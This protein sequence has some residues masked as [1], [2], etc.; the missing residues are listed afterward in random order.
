MS[1]QSREDFADPWGLPA[2]QQDQEW[3]EESEPE[4][5]PPSEPTETADVQEEQPP[6]EAEEAPE[7]EPEPPEETPGPQEPPQEPEEETPQPSRAGAD[8]P[9]MDESRAEDDARE[10]EEQQPSIR[11]G[12]L[13]QALAAAQSVIGSLAHTEPAPPTEAEPE[14]D[15]GTMAQ[16]EAGPGP[17]PIAEEPIVEA[18]PEP[19]QVPSTELP[20]APPPWVLEEAVE[21]E[22]TVDEEIVAEVPEGAD[23]AEVVEEVV[24]EEF[25]E[26]TASSWLTD[27]IEETVSEEL[28][29]ELAEGEEPEPD[30]LARLVS[31]LAEEEVDPDQIEEVVDEL[32]VETVTIER[33]DD[34]PPTVSVQGA[35]QSWWSGE[36]A[37]TAEDRRDVDWSDED[38][39]ATEPFEEPGEAAPSGDWWGGERPT[40]TAKEV[41]PVQEVEADE[42]VADAAPEEPVDE[43]EPAAAE[44]STEEPV[45]PVG[46]HAPEENIPIRLTGEVGKEEEEGDTTP[47]AYSQLAAAAGTDERESPIEP[48]VAP[49]VEW[50]AL[51][52]E[53]AQ[54]WVED[55][56]GQATWRPIVTTTPVLS[57]WEVDTYLGVVAGE[58]MV[59]VNV[60]ELAGGLR[61]VAGGRGGGY[62][63]ELG[64]SRAAAVRSMVEEA[65]ARGSHAV[66]G[67]K[68]DYEAVGNALLVTASGTAV[69]LKSR[70]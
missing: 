29:I 51:W 36:E 59:P 42:P 43:Q 21:V 5:P 57:D 19:V 12:P 62:E 63:K 44:W 9:H 34:E 61:T 66:I 2:Q 13:S 22:V 14:P 39:A 26:E 16:E 55:E 28:V 24:E 64:R 15:E 58:A 31:E 56:S 47:A 49:A 33:V 48:S 32:D 18:P 60:K 37:A 53:S 45:Q 50:G 65:V 41:E 30:E 25:P 35:E 27:P 3:P 54:G 70:G 10:V 67:A 8:E 11:P 7:P 4:S 23:L 17:V 69:T 1:D 68:V 40:E 20:D 6:S 52:R 38:E 46:E